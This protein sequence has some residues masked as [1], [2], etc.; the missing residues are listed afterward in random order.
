M[1][2]LL[3]V[4]YATHLLTGRKLERLSLDLQVPLAA[5][6]GYTSEAHLLASEK[7][8][9]DYYRRARELHLFCE[10]VVA[11]ATA[12]E[13]RTPR[14][15]SLAR[16]GSSAEPF[17]IK[18]GK[19][20]LE[21]AQLFVK[22]PLALF[23]A[24]ALGQAACVPFS[25][26]LHEAIRRSLAQVNREFRAS[27]AAAESFLKLL[28]RRGRVGH[29]LRL[30][31]EVGFL[32][33]YLPEFGRIQMLIQHDLYHHYTVDEHTLK[34]IEALDELHNSRGRKR[35]HLRAVLDEVK[36]VALLY[37]AL[38]LHDIGKG[39]GHGHVARGVQLAER[40]CRRLQLEEQAA[41]CVVRLV[42][43][44]ITMAHISQRRDLSEPRV[45]VDFAA[46]VGSLDG[47][48]ML[49]LLSYADMNGVG[50]GV[51]SE[52]KGSLL[53]ELYERT[54][55]QLTGDAVQLD[56]PVE[57][58]QLKEQIMSALQGALPLSEVERHLALLPERYVRNTGAA[59]AAAHLLLIKHLAA[60]V[61]SWHWTERG[62]AGTELTVCTH[63]R[64]G[65]FADIA[66]T[67]AAQGVEILSAEINTREDGI[68][69]DVFMLRAAATRQAVEEHKRLAIERALARGDQGRSGSRGA[70][71]KV[72]DAE[73]AAPPHARA[74][75]AP[76][77]PAASRLRQRS[78]P[79]RDDHRSACG[80][81]TRT[82]L[83]DRK[84]CDRA[85]S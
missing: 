10:A 60:D 16:A 50:P 62:Q 64:H 30:M 61:F 20:E 63:D 3:R 23:D 74:A 27:S 18:D 31:H 36:D 33:R 6:F 57:L 47:L 45:A 82:R 38:L 41:A 71:R 19:L 72:A 29:V 69:I 8:M 68:A 56:G 81:R 32:S 67:L 4:R 13:K 2:I 46:Q 52:W 15:F 73:R 11:R 43:Q 58:A 28:R 44:H 5:E 49:L 22:Q 7:F 66:G 55:R 85:R 40:I 48:N 37:L 79:R 75:R 12:P 78:G 34:V 84:R 83:Q 26:S 76:P 35:A 54:R 39:R 80:R 59:T 24:F 21:D 14:W 65:L 53:W 77:Q 51:W 1:I 70:G 9:R 17:S 42:A 25:H